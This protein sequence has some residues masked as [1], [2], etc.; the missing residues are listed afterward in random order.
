MLNILRDYLLAAQGYMIIGRILELSY[1][2][3]YSDLVSLAES[4]ENFYSLTDI[5]VISL[6]IYITYTIFILDEN[7][8]KNKRVRILVI[9]ITMATYILGFI[10]LLLFTNSAF[11]AFF[12]PNMAPHHFLCAI[13]GYWITFVN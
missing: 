13:N 10:F 5:L 7:P 9:G 12:A 3:I 1:Y 8:K 2:I 11:Q 6:L 4:I